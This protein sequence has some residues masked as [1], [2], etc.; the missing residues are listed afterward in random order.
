MER[1]AAARPPLSRSG[2]R[3]SAGPEAYPHAVVDPDTVPPAPVTFT[4]WPGPIGTLLIAASGGSI[5]RLALPGYDRTTVLGSLETRFG[6]RTH[7]VHISPTSTA[8]QL[9]PG[10]ARTDEDLLAIAIDELRRYFAGDLQ[11]FTVPVD[12]G[13]V[14]GFRRSVLEETSRIA[15]AETRSYADV[16]A[17]AGSPRAVRA[18]GSALGSNPVALIVPCHRVIRSGG[19]PGH[20]GGGPELKR[21]LLDHEAGLVGRIAPS[22]PR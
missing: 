12:P 7:G 18:A 15:F 20:Y 14:R 11:R 2:S 17:A 22:A 3:F 16:A 21:H 6:A 4:E 1:G 8:R 19:E 13:P 9:K 5:V 10:T